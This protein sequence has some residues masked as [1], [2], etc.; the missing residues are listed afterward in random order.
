MAIKK[1]KAIFISSTVT[2]I[3]LVGLLF[4]PI[5][6]RAASVPPPPYLDF[7]IAPFHPLEAKIW[8]DGGDTPLHGSNISVDS[9][10]GFGTPSNNLVMMKIFDG[11][12]NFETGNYVGGGSNYWEFSGGG[13]IT[14]N[15]IVDFNRNGSAD[16]SPITILTGS[17][18][19]AYVIPFPNY[20][21]ILITG[22]SDTKNIDL[23]SFY[24]LPD[25]S[26]L[27]NMNLSFFGIGDPPG[28]F[29]S[30]KVLSGDLVNI[31]PVPTTMILLTTGVL[32]L[33]GIGFYNR[34]FKK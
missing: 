18:K 14:L 13:R 21:D 20:F 32:G 6:S 4:F 33:I 7:L 8:Y 19:A 9:V 27:G 25:I 28:S 30:I 11:I 29:T 26:Y 3:V 16:E 12:L 23:T 2:V 5:S 17:F 34:R 22:F 15:G 31:V 24:G 10:V 1:M